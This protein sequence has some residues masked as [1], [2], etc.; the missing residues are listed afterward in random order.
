MEKVNRGHLAGLKL[1]LNE[2]DTVSTDSISVADLEYLIAQASVAPG[3][4]AARF[5]RL[6]REGEWE[7]I[8]HA[9]YEKSKDS[10]GIYQCRALYTHADPSEVERLRDELNTERLRADAAVGDAN[11]AEQKLAD[12]QALLREM[13]EYLSRRGDGEAIHTG[14]KFH[15]AIG[16]FLSATAQPAL[17]VARILMPEYRE[18]DIRSPVYG[19]ARGFNAALDEIASLNGV[20][21]DE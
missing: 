6:D 15:M 12:A 8:S 21:S 16:D 14:S 18:T 4:K 20:K 1:A 7:V 3:Q 11:E 9:E 17:P 13:D 5:E 10:A 2:S 19:Y